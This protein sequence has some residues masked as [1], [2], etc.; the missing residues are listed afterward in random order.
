MTLPYGL[1]GAMLAELVLRGKL[2]LGE[3]R[4]LVITD[5]TPSGIEV[6]DE[7]LA[8]VAEATKPRPADVWINTLSHKKY[9]KRIVAS[10][11]EKGVLTQEEKRLFWVI[12]YAV[13]PQ[14]DA[15]AKFW[16]KQRLRGTALAAEKPEPR[17]VI[18]LNLLKACRMLVFVF[19]KDERKAASRTIDQLLQSDEL[20]QVLGQAII[21]TIDAIDAS[22]AAVMLAS[23]STT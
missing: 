19:T 2:T 12:P 10:L 7:A 21:E 23:T 15:S 16:V 5:P 3:K 22:V 17:T 4:R 18:L 1:A 8:K 6:L 11:I 14:Q 13:Y 20:G 9:E